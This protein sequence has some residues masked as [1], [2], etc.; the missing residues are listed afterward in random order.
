MLAFKVKVWTLVP[1]MK[2]QHLRV[3][4]LNSKTF[5]GCLIYGEHLYVLEDIKMHRKIF[6]K[7]LTFVGERNVFIAIQKYVIVF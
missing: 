4:F 6:V 1:C 5:I 2:E 7:E 3:N